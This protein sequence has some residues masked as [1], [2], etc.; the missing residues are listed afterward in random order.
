M[1]SMALTTNCRHVVGVDGLPTT[2]RCTTN[3]VRAR[4]QSVMTQ[5]VL[6][7][8]VDEMSDLSSLAGSSWSASTQREVGFGD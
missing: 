5:V 4:R 7:V 8:Q 6:L 2:I 1:S 3:G